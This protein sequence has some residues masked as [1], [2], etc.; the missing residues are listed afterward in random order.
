MYKLN[1]KILGYIRNLLVLSELV[2]A[3]ASNLIFTFEQAFAVGLCQQFYSGEDRSISLSTS[4]NE[5]LCIK[6][7]IDIGRKANEVSLYFEARF[8]WPGH[9]NRSEMTLLLISTERKPM[10]KLSISTEKDGSITLKELSECEAS[11][12]LKFYSS[13]FNDRILTLLPGVKKLIEQ[14]AEKDNLFA[15][16]LLA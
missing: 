9:N 5:G 4:R 16:E 14:E 10:L 11:D 12:R 8:T 2:G 1:S 13:S 15:N 6:N 3:G 7:K